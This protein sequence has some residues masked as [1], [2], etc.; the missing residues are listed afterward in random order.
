MKHPQPRQ[1]HKSG[2]MIYKVSFR[3]VE[4]YEGDI[5]EVNIKETKKSILGVP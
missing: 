2:E 4:S 5:R 1:F 3:I